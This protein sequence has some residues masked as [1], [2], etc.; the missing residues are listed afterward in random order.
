MHGRARFI[1][2]RALDAGP[3]PGRSRYMPMPIPGRRA[4]CRAARAGPPLDADAE[5]R[6][7]DG[8]R[9]ALHV[10]PRALHAGRALDAGPRALDAGTIWQHKGTSTRFVPP[11]QRAMRDIAAR[12]LMVAPLLLR[13]SALAVRLRQPFL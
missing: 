1:P 11:S 10:D 12:R 6:A 7:M 4:A 3:M 5:P 2:G 9:R 8:G 13:R